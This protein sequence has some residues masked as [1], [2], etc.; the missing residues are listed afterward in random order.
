[1]ILNINLTKEEEQKAIE[2]FVRQGKTLEEGVKSLL[3]GIISND[4]LNLPND[5]PTARLKLKDTGCFDFT[6]DTSPETISHIK[7]LLSFE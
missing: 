7:D 2:F 5:I 3:L 6:E 4:P 1:M